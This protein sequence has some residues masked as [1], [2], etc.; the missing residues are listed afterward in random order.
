MNRFRVTNSILLATCVAMYWNRR[1]GW[2]D[3]H[4]HI[5]P[6]DSYEVTVRTPDRP[7]MDIWPPITM[8]S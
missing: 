4:W 6:Y 8:L 3:T 1:A 7:Q 2:T 5:F